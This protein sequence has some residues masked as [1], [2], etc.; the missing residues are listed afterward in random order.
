MRIALSQILF[1]DEKYKYLFVTTHS[2]FVL[3]EM[4]GVNL[5]RIFSE[6]KINSKSVFHKL[7]S[8]FEKNRKMLNRCLAEAIFANRV[9]LVEGPSEYAL[10]NKVLSV[11]HPFYEADGIYI[12]PV[13]GVGFE[14]YFTILNKLEIANF[15]KTDNDLRKVKSSNDYS[16]LGFSRCNGYIGQAI[17]PKT[18]I[19]DGTVTSK[20]ALYQDNKEK[21]DQISS[22]YHIFLSKV[23]LENDLDECMHE[24]L[25]EL[26]GD[27][28]VGFLQSSKNYNMI[29]LIE[30]LS[31][32]DCRT[33]YNHYNFVC[34][35]E[36]C[37]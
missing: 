5:I 7:P 3:Y 33:I 1:S 34:L 35:K 24:R 8:N 14:L 15:I 4:N 11:I 27:D 37:E 31:D 26:I 22:E 9:L 6:R 23:D 18:R 30:K 25:C 13:S 12:L 36:V 16:L 29:E 21:L 19:K 17:L 28:P 10:F 2:P 32:D 20:R